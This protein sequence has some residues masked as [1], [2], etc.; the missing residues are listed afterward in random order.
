HVW[1]AVVGGEAVLWGPDLF[2]AVC[3]MSVPYSPPGYVDILAELE[4]G[5]INDFYLQYFQKPG[6]AEAEL[7][8]DIR[9]AL[10]RIYFTAGGDIEEKG[11]GFARLTGGSLLANTVDPPTL[12]RCLSEADLD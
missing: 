10:R 11:K 3:G 1:G 6:I 2:T 9:S 8:Q 12:P 4:K 5:G 7:Q